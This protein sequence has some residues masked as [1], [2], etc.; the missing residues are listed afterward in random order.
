MKKFL[1]MTVL[2][3]SLVACEQQTKPNV[4]S[5]NPQDTEY[6]DRNNTESYSSDNTGI[7]NRNRD[8]D[9]ATPFDQS[10]SEADRVITQKIRKALIADNSLSTNAKNIKIITIKGIVTLRG[11]VD[12]TQEKDIIAKKVSN[13][14]GI[15]KVAN[16]LEVTPT[17]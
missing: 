7:N 5:Q 13:I 11:P 10:E 1:L 16:Q 15:R 8:A 2:S 12:S 4:T 9:T 14:Q 3:L 17:N 6:S